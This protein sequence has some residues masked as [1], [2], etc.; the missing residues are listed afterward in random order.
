MYQGIENRL[1][2]K[3]ANVLSLTN[4]L[5]VLVA[6]VYWIFG[7]NVFG[8]R[9]TP[10]ISLLSDN[11]RLLFALLLF[12][13]LALAIVPVLIPMH[14]SKEEKGTHLRTYGGAMVVLIFSVWFL[15]LGGAFK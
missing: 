5:F 8:M 3:I 7:A 11:I 10:D 12:L 13:N 6:I 1:H 2:I 9:T 15:F 4:F 14:V